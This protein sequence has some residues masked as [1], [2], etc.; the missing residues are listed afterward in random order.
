MT[1][2]KLNGTLTPVH[3][4][5]TW[6]KSYDGGKMD[7]FV[8]AAEAAGDRPR[9]P[10]RTCRNR[11]SRESYWT[12]AKAYGIGDRMFQSNT[13]GSFAA[14]LYLIAGQA[15]LER[16][17]LH[18][19]RQSGANGWGCGDPPGLD[20]WIRFEPRL[21]HGGS[22]A[23]PLSGPCRRSA[24]SWTRKALTPGATTRAPRN[25]IWNEYEALPYVFERSGLVD[26]YRELRR[27]AS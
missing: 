14:H 13:G 23:V 6:F 20:T 4:H 21:A 18:P 3:T 25:R 7:G 1:Q 11:R 26:R 16:R 5:T 8:N 17:P 12:L 27:R 22:G 15:D 2:E 24:K 10:S 19:R 9:R